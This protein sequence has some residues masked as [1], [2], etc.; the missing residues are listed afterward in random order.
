MAFTDFYIQ[1]TG[2]NMNGGTTNSN[3][4]TITVTYS[5]RV[6]AVQLYS[7]IRYPVRRRSRRN[8]GEYLHQRRNYRRIPHKNRHH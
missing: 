8:L 3:S 1:T 6:V 4:A 5:Y 7:P 2:N